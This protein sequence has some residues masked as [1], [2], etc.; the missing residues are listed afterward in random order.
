MT[1]VE[2]KFL[3]EIGKISFPEKYLKWYRSIIHKRI[4]NPCNDFEKHHIYPVSLNENWKNE[5]DNIVKLSPREHYICHLLL[6]KM[7][8]KNEHRLKM[9]RCVFLISNRTGYKT[10]R[11]YEHFRM[12]RSEAMMAD[13]PMKRKVNQSKVSSALKGRTKHTHRYIVIASEKKSQYKENNTEWVKRSREKFREYIAKMTPTERKETFT[14]HLTEEKRKALFEKL[15]LERIGRTSSNCERVK[16]MSET[17]KR[18]ASKLSD[19]EKKKVF[20]KTKGFKWFHN[21]ELKISKL[22]KPETIDVSIWKL[23]RVFYENSKD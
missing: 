8:L 21:E 2:N 14:N 11:I 12:K 19:E 4:L 7:L 22:M 13:N 3:D 18:N 5:N 9:E 1:L 20:G 15:S 6:A 23:G 16:K 10:S 17:K